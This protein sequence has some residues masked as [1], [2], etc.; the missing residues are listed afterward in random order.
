MEL[1]GRNDI[2]CVLIF[3]LVVAERRRRRRRRRETGDRWEPP[4]DIWQ[5]FLL[6]LTFT[7]SLAPASHPARLPAC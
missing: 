5:V 6:T 1:A 4:S 2:I 3:C 7:L